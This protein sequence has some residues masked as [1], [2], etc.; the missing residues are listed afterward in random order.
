MA[1]PFATV[2][3]I[4]A[5]AAASAC[6][7]GGR[8]GTL[9]GCADVRP[10]AAL[11]PISCPFSHASREAVLLDHHGR[12]APRSYDFQPTRARSRP[13]EPDRH[14]EGL[15][16]VVPRRGTAGDHRRHLADRG[17]HR[18]ARRRIRRLQ[19]RRAAV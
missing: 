8:S 4:P 18:L 15:V 11:T 17:L 16:P 19:V 7:E 14:P 6:G 5:T 9:A 13:T 2:T 12:F 1:Q 3:L 10:L